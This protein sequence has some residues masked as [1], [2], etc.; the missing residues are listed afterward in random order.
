MKTSAQLQ[1][2]INSIEWLISQALK[3]GNTT[4]AN[5]LQVVVGRL[6]DEFMA[7]NGISE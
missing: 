4:K 5:E 2:D 1:E 7:L 3:N 6:I